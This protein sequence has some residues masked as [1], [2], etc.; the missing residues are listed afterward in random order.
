M[1]ST[2]SGR[3]GSGKP[4]GACSRRRI[5][6]SLQRRRLPKQINSAIR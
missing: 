5:I 6:I 1:T 2:G 4:L 3:S